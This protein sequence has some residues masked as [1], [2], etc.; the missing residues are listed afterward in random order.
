MKDKQ[1]W[2]EWGKDA[3]IVL[4]TLSAVYLLS[5]TPLIQDSGLVDILRPRQTAGS[6][7]AGAARTE[8]VLPV[9]LAVYRDGERFGLQSDDARM[10]ELFAALDP[11]LRD[12][13]ASAGEPRTLTEKEWQG[14]LRQES[15]YF[16]F[17]GDVPLTAL[18]RWLGGEGEKA[19]GG[20]ARRI[21]LTAGEDDQVLLCWQDGAD[22]TFYACGTAL[23][24]AL[25]LDPAADGIAANGAYFAFEDA[26][27]G[28]L[29]DPD[30]LITEGKRTGA[31]YAVT[32]PLANSAGVEALLEAL[33]FN[34]QNH[35]PGSGGEV[36]LDGVD[37]LV[38]GDSGTVTYRAAGEGKYPVGG[39]AGPVT[40]AQAAEETGA[41]AE[42]AMIPPLK[43]PMTLILC[44]Q[45]LKAFSNA[46]TLLMKLLTAI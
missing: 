6:G 7:S 14:C 37:R 46:G 17:S 2:I 21:A 29:L 40:A 45:K 3:L 8:A 26:E 4:L 13:L 30:T 11:V 27:L 9:R 23:S 20:S 41:I 12:A 42:K 33:S 34:S 22:G 44:L 24:R 28:R 36:Y 25:H 15:V 35:V 19:P 10:T 39:Q 1:R 5:M 32:A 43:N 16:D 31:Q 38:V 18:S